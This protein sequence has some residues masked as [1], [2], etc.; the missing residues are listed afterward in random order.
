MKGD[1]L[2]THRYL[3]MD[4]TGTEPKSKGKDPTEKYSVRK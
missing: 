3:P 2:A 4:D 1:A